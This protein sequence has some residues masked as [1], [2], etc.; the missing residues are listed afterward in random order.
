MINLAYCVYLLLIA[1]VEKSREY[2][3]NYSKKYYQ[4]NSI[5]IRRDA[6][7]WREE[8]LDRAK[9][10]N[11]QWYENNKERAKARIKNWAVKNPEKVLATH[12]KWDEENRDKKNAWYKNNKPKVNADKMR[13]YYSEPGYR[14]LVNLR[15]RVNRALKDNW[16]SGRTLVLLGCSIAELRQRLESRFKTGMTWENYGG[17]TGWQ[18]DHI[19]PCAKFDLT[20]PAQQRECFHFSN[21]Q[22]LWAIDNIKKGDRYGG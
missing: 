21:L 18:I 16:K 4:E 10:S 12:R 17:K 20:D 22:P 7:K 15:T 6:K 13:R 19:K 11:K 8:N 1:R 9:A 5:K 14:L 2:Q 3:K